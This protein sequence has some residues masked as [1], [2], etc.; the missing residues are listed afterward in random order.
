MA[1]SSIE[2]SVCEKLGYDT[3][4]LFSPALQIKSLAISQISAIQAALRGYVASDQAVFDAALGSLYAQTA[5]ILPGD[6]LDDIQKVLNII[7][8]CLYLRGNDALNN[9]ISL[10]TAFIRSM[11]EKISAFID[12]YTYLPE[13]LLGKLLSL[14]DELYG[15]ILPGSRAI[16]EAL[17]N[18]DQIINCLSNFCGGEFTA[19]VIILTN[20]VETLYNDLWIVSDPLSANYGK[21]D[22]TTL[23]SD[24]GL[25]PTEIAKVLQ[26]NT[27]I[28]SIKASAQTSIDNFSNCHCA[29]NTAKSLK[30][31]PSGQTK[32]PGNGFCHASFG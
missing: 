25:T 1:L 2:R 31:T 14:L 28:N 21:L 9:P 17:A 16:S 6:S 30:S 29:P 19:Q 15:D 8:N 22:K 27:N 20:D 32:S 12:D 5:T 4:G 10:T 18:I 26:V 24:A 7:N 3:G 13:F 11:I 23:F